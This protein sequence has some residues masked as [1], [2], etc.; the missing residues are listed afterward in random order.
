[1]AVVAVMTDP[2]EANDMKPV[3]AH[4][5]IRGMSIVVAGLVL[6]TGAIL[7]PGAAD[8]YEL[9]HRTVTFYDPE[10]S[11]REIST[12]IYYP[13]D[14]AGDDVPLAEPPAGGFPVVTFG[15]GFVMSIDDY[16][17]LWEGLAPAGYIVAL[18]RTETGFSPDH[19]DLG[20]D[21]A[22]L[23][24]ALRD[25][26]EDPASPFFGKVAATC[27]LSGHSMG[28]GASFLGAASDPSVTALFNFAAAETN[29]SAIGAAA[30]I[31]APALLFAGSL[32][33]VTPPPNHQQPMYDA[34]ASD[35]RTYV[36]LL[37]A[38]HCQFAEYNY[39]CSLGELGCQDPEI[40]RQEQH[41]LTLLFLIPWLD[42]FLYEDAP[43]WETFQT[44]LAE[45]PGI[46]YEQDCAMSGLDDLVEVIDSV[47]PG[48]A[49]DPL[50]FES[51][52]VV[53]AGAPLA[54]RLYLPAPGNLHVTIHDASGRRMDERNRLAMTAGWHT[55][56]WDTHS[57]AG[58]TMPAGV[59]FG[60]ARLSAGERG[61]FLGKTR[62]MLL[63]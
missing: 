46:V 35:C 31:T 34:L 11:N 3:Q 36:E 13:A 7:V 14:V 52:S 10:R 42:A 50:L 9:G 37:G 39:L 54:L 30:Q 63:R 6:L 51:P 24:R 18:P 26:G 8:A 29:P 17:F 5:R 61:Q 32:D 22:F 53:I 28:G 23:C 62:F 33:C 56:T 40:S 48:G 38:S 1:V 57:G 19:L 25:E 44:L 45:T 15:H 60:R 20:L 16:D 49:V 4:S 47:P 43:A 58:G 41:A 55:L 21:L 59:Y 12:E 2:T 27:A